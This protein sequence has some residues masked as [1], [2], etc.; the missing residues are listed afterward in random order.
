MLQVCLA[1]GDVDDWYNEAG[2]HCRVTPGGAA[3]LATQPGIPLRLPGYLQLKYPSPSA[4]CILG[5]GGPADTFYIYPGENQGKPGKMGK[6]RGEF[7][8]N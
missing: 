2:L 5:R 4:I 1:D 6:N 7:A 3:A 8:T